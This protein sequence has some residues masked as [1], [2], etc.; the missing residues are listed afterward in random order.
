[1]AKLDDQKTGRIIY[2][3]Q[4]ILSSFGI[5]DLEVIGKIDVLSDKRYFKLRTT[6]KYW[7]RVPISPWNAGPDI[8]RM[9]QSTE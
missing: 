6:E 4:S 7:Q 9:P 1:M 2:S 8:G 3:V 5:K